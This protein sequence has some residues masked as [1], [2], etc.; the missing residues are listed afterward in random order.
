MPTVLDTLHKGTEYLEKHGIDEARLNMQHLLAHAL[1]CDRMQ[2]YLNFDRPIAE[3]ELERL[4]ELTK[5]RGQG[6]PLQHLLEVIEFCGRDFKT[7]SRALIPRPETE[8]LVEIL[9]SRLWPE[10][11]RILDV[12]TGSGVI[13]LTLA[14]ELTGKDPRVVLADLSEEALELARENREKLGLGEDKVSLIQSD[15]FAAIDGAFDL[16]A[17]NLPYVALAEMPDLS[18][19]VRADPETALLGG[20]NGTEIIARFLAACGPHLN[21]GGAIALEFGADQAAALKVMAE[22]AGLDSV[23]IRK[24]TS[25]HDRFLFAV[26]RGDSG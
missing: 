1:K 3:P 17:A 19:E 23:E 25:G 20:E 2:L 12:G 13:G 10:G 24:D 26:K 7:D 8:E 11:V 18:R 15:L 6:E 22:D 5:R 21:P 16:I 4:R 14:A 9:K